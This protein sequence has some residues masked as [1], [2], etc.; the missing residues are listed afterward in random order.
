MT[1]SSPTMRRAGAA[2][3]NSLRDHP[4]GTALLGTG[5]VW[6]IGSR[7][8]APQ[9]VG[10]TLH[11]A[12]DALAAGGSQVGRAA[13]RAVDTMTQAGGAATDGLSETAEVATA[14]MRD[15]RDQFRVAARHGADDATMASD[16]TV[17][18]FSAYSR[19]AAQSLSGAG[20]AASVQMRAARD[21]LS[22]TLQNEPL[23]LAAGGLAVGAAIAATLPISNLESRTVGDA[24]RDV[25]GAAG[26]RARDALSEAVERVDQIA[27]AG[28]DEAE[29]QGLTP[30]QI[31]RDAGSV[32]DKARAAA[33]DVADDLQNRL[34]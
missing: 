9:I 1:A 17:D 15:A 23:L 4:L 34:L 2:L 8:G 21:W 10:R 7:T 18:R 16:D 24:A 26:D 33:G 3:S 11:A 19:D 20:A 31:A 22:R 30:G 28:K 32:A 5:L 25:A 13:G 14:A 29:R 6:L 27:R 12:G